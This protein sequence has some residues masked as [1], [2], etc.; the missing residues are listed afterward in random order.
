MI[1]DLLCFTNTCNKAA[2]YSSFSYNIQIRKYLTSLYSALNLIW[3]SKLD[4]MSY[5][6]RSRDTFSIYVVRSSA[7]C[8][9]SENCIKRDKNWFLREN[10]ITNNTERNGQPHNWFI[11]NLP[12]AS[13][14]S[15]FL[16]S[17][18]HYWRS[19]QPHVLWIIIFLIFLMKF[20]GKHSLWCLFPSTVVILA[21]A[22]MTLK[23]FVMD[24]FFSCVWSLIVDT[25]I[26][27]EVDIQNKKWR[28][29]INTSEMEV[30]YKNRLIMQP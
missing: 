11:T 16:V 15:F 18:F 10:V 20:P 7:R 14:V 17:G 19:C 27:H 6:F 3:K 8:F 24:M 1:V 12:T 25:L 21:L 23:E 30:F 4:D 5:T 13:E 29:H 9:S 2:R 26:F 22:A 28:I